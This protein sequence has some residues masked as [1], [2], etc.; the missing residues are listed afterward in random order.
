MN[1]RAPRTAA[2][3][4]PTGVDLA[5]V[6]TG[7]GEEA[8]SDERVPGAAEESETEPKEG[9]DPG[10]DALAEPPDA[11]EWV[12]DGRDEEPDAAEVDPDEPAD[13][14]AGEAGETEG[15]PPDGVEV[16]VFGGG[17]GEDGVPGVIRK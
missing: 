9:E 8:E 14:G 6:E 7:T 1:S 13:E 15:S 3:I 17:A 4:V 5:A 12:P 11:I 16:L 10:E 2:A